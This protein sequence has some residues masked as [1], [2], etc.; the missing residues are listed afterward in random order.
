MLDL[1]EYLLGLHLLLN[2]YLFHL[3][4]LLYKEKHLLLL[5]HLSL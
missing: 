3:L 2:N 5:L 4:L 1:L